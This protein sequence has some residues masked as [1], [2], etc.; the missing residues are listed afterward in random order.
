MNKQVRWG[1]LSSARI[2]QSALTPAIHAAS[3]AELTCLGTPNAE[4]VNESA[5]QYGYRPLPSYDA[6]LADPEVDAVYNPLPNGMHAEWTIRALEAGK[7][8]LCEKPFS[9]TVEESEQMVAASRRAGRWLM[10]AFMYR[11][12]PQMELAKRTL[13]SGRI[14]TLRL[15]RTCF[16][17]NLPPN[18]VNPRFQ[19]DQGPG[20]LLDVGSY[21]VNATRFFSGRPPLAVTACSSWDEASGGDLT[22]AGLLEYERHAALFDCSFEAGGRSGIELVGSEGRMDIP[23]PWLPGKDPAVIRVSGRDGAEDLTTE[24][25]DQYQLMVEHFSDCI[26]NN[27]PPVRPPEDALE[28]MRVLEAIRRSARER[29]RVDVPRD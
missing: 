18:P 4:K 11:F 1:I 14:G 6:V 13:D 15:I 22:T 10:E 24:G 8:V 9:V 5:A 26:L 29:R 2:A 16:T 23:K 3:N 20:A 17:F 27:N 7:H 19:R 21:C 25:V 12:H 28:N